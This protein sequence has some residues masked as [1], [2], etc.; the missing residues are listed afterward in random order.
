MKIELNVFEQAFRI[1]CVD[2]GHSVLK[3]S[4]CNKNEKK[5]RVTQLRAMA[6]HREQK[7]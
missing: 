4:L 5:I 6:K 2:Y 7:L 3:F 1:E